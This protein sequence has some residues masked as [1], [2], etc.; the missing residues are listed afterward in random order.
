MLRYQE[1]RYVPYQAEQMYLLV[2]AVEKYPEFL[3]WC[4][5]VRILKR[6]DEILL[7][8]LM[9]GY[10]MIRESFTSLVHFT[11]SSRIDV[12]HKGGPF[13]RLT[14]QWA[15]EDTENNGSFGCWINFYADFAFRSRVLQSLT[16]LLF[17]ELVH[18]MVRA[19]EKRA[20]TIYG[21]LDSTYTQSTYS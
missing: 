1:R 10:K 21:S 11:P 8:D 2:A 17:H 20:Y 12:E 5:G 16:K 15:F 13:K 19:F 14:I 6:N 3:P 4:T 18:R 7:A 9:V